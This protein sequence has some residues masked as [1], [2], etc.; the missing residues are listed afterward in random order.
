MMN[1]FTYTSLA[2]AV[3]CTFLALI[4]LIKG[5]R[6]NLNRS[7]AIVTCF[8]GMWSLFP[9]VTAIAPDN[10]TAVWY[11]RLIYTAAVF[12]PATFLDFVFNLIR[13]EKS[14]KE[15]LVLASSYVVSALFFF[16]NFT[17][18]LIK[19][20]VRFQPQFYVV[21]GALYPVFILYFGAVCL[22]AFIKL[23]AAF[24]TAG[25]SR[26]NQYKYIFFAFACAYLGGLM[27][28]L[29]V[30]FGSQVEFF[31]HDILLIAFAAIVAYSILQYRL[32]DIEFIIKKTVFYS[33]LT[34]LLTGVFLSAIIVGDYWLR[35]IVGHGSLW[36]GILAAFV[37]ALF[38]QPLRD[39]IQNIVDRLF[40]RSRYNYQ[41]I[42]RKYSASLIRPMSDLS[43]FAR[44][45]PYLIWRS[46]KLSGASF[47]SLDRE[48]RCYVVRA[49]VG[50]REQ[51]QGQTLPLNSALIA[52]LR[53][54]LREINLEEVNESLKTDGRL[55][56]AARA[57]L[58]QLKAELEQLGAVLV[59]PAVSES[60]YF[61]EPTLLATLNLGKKLSDE[62]YSK[63]D[64]NFLEMLANQA[65]ISIENGFILEELK[66]NQEQVLKSE[67][68]A[69]LGSTVAGIAH[70]LKNP[71]TYLLTA[72]QAMASSW[73]NPAFKESVIKMFP[74]EVERMKL[75][76]DGLS[77]YSKTR[78]LAIEPVELT[79][80][81]DK[82]LA[83]L[84]YE[85][86]KNNVFIIKKYPEGSEPAAVAL[87]DK[88][89]IV[90]VFMNIISNG[91][92][93]MAGKGGDL[94]IAV[95]RQ[96]GEVRVCVSD[97]GPG[98]PADQRQKIFDPFFTTKA[99]GTGL[100]L[101]ITKKIVDEHKGAIFIDSRPGEGTTFTI[102]L[103]AAA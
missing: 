57:H 26:R 82:T 103:P 86:K 58:L 27:H 65:A 87:A 54:N 32:M 68:L 95:R 14:K 81:I 34:A 46:L 43:R 11:D 45:A 33:L 101:S 40:F 84:G 76:I 60:K 10:L 6:N 67:K 15:N 39:T 12:V 94:T 79:A 16:L 97:S 17:P 59:M 36:V 44:L 61:K 41:S 55:A 8:A 78:E 52:D 31:P 49:G 29:P 63:E 66:K 64:A 92:Q 42:I 28:F 47:M 38:F 20:V 98:I 62:P 21:P 85:I 37:I 2:A 70:E 96:G 48:G 93:A 7:F 91:V 90:Q 18:L 53:Q 83:V 30:Y 89:R 99:A 24:R 35:S 50:D 75:I 88:N 51:A 25:G 102:C 77:D 73:D 1:I 19:N 100:G 69:S 13:R 3:L 74:S 72:A 9:F 56:P 22:Y 4:V 71:L 23:L 5:V 80:V